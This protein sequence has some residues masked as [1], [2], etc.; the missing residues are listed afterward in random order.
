MR[1]QPMICV[2]SVEGSSAWFQRVLGLVSAHGGSEYEQLTVD[3][4]LVLQLHAWD[5][6]DHPHLGDPAVKPYGNGALLWFESD[7]VEQD[8]ARAVAAGAKVLEP[9]HINPL[10]NHLE[11]WLQ[12][13]NGYVVV[14]A[15]PYGQVG[16]LGKN[17]A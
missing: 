7:H 1:P 9:L 8:Y 16:S 6:H 5:R 15:S 10:A 11:F 17:A 3:G 4:Q 2:A 14:V 13:P 12:E